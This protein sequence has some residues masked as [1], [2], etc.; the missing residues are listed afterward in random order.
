MKFEAQKDG[1]GAVFNRQAVCS[2][3]D[4]NKDGTVFSLG[5]AVSVEGTGVGAGDD[6]HPMPDAAAVAPDP[7]NS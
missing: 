1:N 4:N 6:L 3:I 2:V 5:S 7:R